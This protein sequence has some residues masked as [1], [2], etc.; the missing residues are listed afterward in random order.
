MWIF[1]FLEA[2]SIDDIVR[3]D[4]DRQLNNVLRIRKQRS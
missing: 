4:N 2:A 1:F 3:I